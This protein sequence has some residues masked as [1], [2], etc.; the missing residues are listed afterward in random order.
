MKPG[1]RTLE[2]RNGKKDLVDEALKKLVRVRLSF[3]I[4]ETLT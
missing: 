3:L 1:G 2:V 4:V